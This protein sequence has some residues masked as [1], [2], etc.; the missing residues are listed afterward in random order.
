LRINLRI[1]FL[2]PAVGQVD[3]LLDWS[4]AA[5]SG[6]WPCPMLGCAP[7]SANTMVT[8]T[9]WLRSA[10]PSTWPCNQTSPRP[11]PTWACVSCL[12]VS[13]MARK[14]ACQ[15]CSAKT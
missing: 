11:T 3:L 13:W 8:G 9:F 5:G 4:L 14:P 2:Y 1:N 7:C 10:P 12:T 15:S 6:A